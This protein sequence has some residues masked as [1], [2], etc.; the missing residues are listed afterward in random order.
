VL[1][2]T[3]HALYHPLPCIWGW[4]GCGLG[5]V[6][7]AAV[8]GETPR[9]TTG[10]HGTP[11]DTSPLCTAACCHQGTPWLPC[12]WH[13]CLCIHAPPLAWFG[14]HPAQRARTSQPPPLQTCNPP[15]PQP[16]SRSPGVTT[17]ALTCNARN[18]CWSYETSDW[19][20]A[21]GGGAC[22]AS[23]GVGNTRSA[24]LKRCPVAHTP[25]KLART[26]RSPGWVA[27][28]TT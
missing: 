14:Q 4:F 9:D 8:V 3:T 13:C 16:A 26:A 25:P 15:T 22:S 2:T 17:S 11:W 21:G 6:Q 24:A 20:S 10:H 7:H 5:V 19:K 23:R 27:Q 18:G 12:A 28:R 1:P